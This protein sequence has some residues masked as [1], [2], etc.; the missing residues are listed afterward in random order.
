[1]SKSVVLVLAIDPY[2]ESLM[3][4]VVRVKKIS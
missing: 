1:M 3:Q 4:R 2:M